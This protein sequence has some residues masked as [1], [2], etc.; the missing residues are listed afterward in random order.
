MANQRLS[1]EVGLQREA[2]R[3]HKGAYD[4]IVVSITALK[5]QYKSEMTKKKA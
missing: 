4:N 5:N 2:A 3:K 1:E